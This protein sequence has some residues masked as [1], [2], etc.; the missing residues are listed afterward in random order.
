M[1]VNSNPTNSI[2]KELKIIHINVNS[3]IKIS[4]RYE[5]DKFIKSNNPDIVLLNET[6]LNNKHKL[7]FEN[8]ILV[9]SDRKG[10]KR[11][12]GTAI[13]VRKEIKFNSISNNVIA[14]FKYLETCIIKIHTDS[15]NLIYIISAYYPPG[16][17]D[18]SLKSELQKLFESLNLENH[19]NYYILV[20]D[21]NCKHTDWGNP[22]NNNKGTIMKDW[23]MNND[24]RFRCNLFASV[25]P[26]Y[27]RSN[28][29]LDIC[30]ADHRIHIQR[31]NH[32]TN[33]LKILPYDSDHVALQIVA[34]KNTH[35]QFKIIQQEE[36]YNYNYKR[37]NWKKF[38]NTIL[39]S[40]ELYKIPNNRNLTNTEIEYYLKTLNNT[41]INA[42]EKSVP[43]FKNKDQLKLFVTPIIKK[44][45][46]EKSRTLTLIKRYNRLQH[47]L[48]FRDLT[49]L[50]CKLKLIRKLIEDNFYISIN[51]YH[52]TKLSR[53]SAS[54]PTHLFSET[55]T[56]YRKHNSTMLETIKI[57]NTDRQLLDKANIN[58][59]NI[60]TETDTNK[61]IIRE[62]S[63]ILNIVGAFMETIYAPKVID[64]G[65][66]IHRDVSEGFN[67]FLEEKS[68]FDSNPT[69][70]TNFS[71]RF[72]AN[73]I[74]ES[75]ENE[76]FIT[77][78][79]IS[80]IFRNLK[81]KLSSGVDN[82]PNII[83]KLFPTA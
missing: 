44:L 47:I 15:N 56:E 28:S 49:I 68:R 63:Q 79:E 54:N 72:I 29:Y 31:E 21:L 16:N 62:K 33:C 19:N 50:K 39:N 67:R 55:K 53:L 81:G 12:G 78:D 51:N 65:N 75:P 64:E 2:S 58:P 26:S 59:Q 37:T 57:A 13:L 5:L 74:N 82:I 41:I 36:K 8:F 27:T 35:E 80:Y 23:L 7:F 10:D 1:I 22:V 70:I 77:R 9:R 46:A 24:I 25:S 43:K 32:T 14:S 83:L 34:S 66:E 3:L 69:Q 48:T 61:F 20:G 45:H 30:I 18:N 76:Y 73:D 71:E 42:I 17:N 52:K 38:Q 11:G 40:L 4:R 6:K 60:E